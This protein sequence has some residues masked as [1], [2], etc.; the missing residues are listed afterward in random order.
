MSSVKNEGDTI[1]VSISTS[2]AENLELAIG[3]EVIFDVQG[4]PI[5]TYIG[6]LR[7]V[8]W[9][10]IQTNFIFVFPVG[11]IDKAPQFYVLMTRTD[12]KQV[13]S[14]YQQELVATFPN[15]STI[16]LTLILKT[17]D[18]FMD[19]IAFVI[20]FMAFFSIATGLVV[21]AGAV[22][23]SKYIRLKENVLL[24]T[25]GAVKRQI[26]KMT[27]LE[28]GYLGLFAGL[29]GILLSLAA[30]W[31]LSIFFFKVLF[32][33]DFVSLSFIWGGIALLTMLIGWLNTRSVINKSP[34]EVLR[35]E[36]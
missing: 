36:G 4:V 1:F 2:M 14:K 8:D 12:D 21:L 26:V 32:F 17:I 5:I 28:Y 33:P 35:R 23:N 18:N 16:D 27:L 7:E 11:V 6:S 24:R 10:R 31:G 19:K 30:A 34:L 15:V 22:I 20:Q 13:A 3:D 9:Q 29:T 25:M